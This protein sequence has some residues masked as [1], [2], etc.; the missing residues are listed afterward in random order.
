[1]ADHFFF[2]LSRTRTSRSTSVSL[3]GSGL[4]EPWV[5]NTNTFLH[6]LKAYCGGAMLP[7]MLTVGQAV[8]TAALCFESRLVTSE[9]WGQLCDF[10]TTLAAKTSDLAWR[11]LFG[12]YCQWAACKLST[13]IEEGNTETDK[14]KYECALSS[15]KN[16]CFF[17]CLTDI[18]CTRYSVVF[19][20]IFCVADSIKISFVPSQGGCEQLMYTYYFIKKINICMPQF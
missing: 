10:L 19:I 5:E 15:V 8:T 20:F 11:I 17:C 3:S 13:I 6:R 4:R 7:N 14:T 18:W 1:M 9:T 2:S 12:I 16:L